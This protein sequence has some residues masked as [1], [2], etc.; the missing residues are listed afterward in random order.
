MKITP[1]HYKDLCR[2]FEKDG[3]KHVRT[4]GDHLVFRKSEF[5]RPIIIPAYKT[6][7]I[8]IILN[9]LRT[10]KLSREEYCKLLKKI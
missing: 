6:V 1:I 7:P 4:K 9:N 10:A 2:V 5:I 8:F 3:W